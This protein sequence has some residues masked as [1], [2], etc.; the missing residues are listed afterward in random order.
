MKLQTKLNDLNKE[1]EDCQKKIEEAGNKRKEL[2]NRRKELQMERSNVIRDRQMKDSEKKNLEKSLKQLQR[3]QEHSRDSYRVF[4]M[5]FE[6]LMADIERNAQ[7][8]SAPPLGPVGKY[9]RLVGA[10]AQNRDLCDLIESDMGRGILRSFVVNTMEDQRELQG[11]FA[12]HF[13]GGKPPNITRLQFRN[14]RI[15]LHDGIRAYSTD[16]YTVVMDH[17]QFDNDM[18]YNYLIS[19]TDIATTL[20]LT[21]DQAEH[22][23]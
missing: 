15:H 17:L 14:D 16:D 22:L 23:G 11:I 12:R 9:V 18:V 8:F 5:E 21:D 3:Q 19:Q 4:G 6:N 10:A 13:R 20:V 7:R 1:R 2:E